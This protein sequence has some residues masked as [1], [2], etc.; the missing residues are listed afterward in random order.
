MRIVN[1]DSDKERPATLF[2]RQPERP[3]D[4]Q[5]RRKYDDR[6]TVMIREAGIDAPLRGFSR[7][8]EDGQV[9][10]VAI[11][12]TLDLLQHGALVAQRL[13][14]LGAPLETVI[15]IERENASAEF[16]L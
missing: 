9:V 13:V 12:M 10:W 6:L 4:L 8:D 5:R 15:E 1:T 2:A 7:L 14:E 11:E 3:D 16:S